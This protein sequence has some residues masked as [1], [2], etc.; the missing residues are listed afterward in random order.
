MSEDPTA[1]MMPIQATSASSQ[2][3]VGKSREEELI[4]ALKA[5]EAEKAALIARADA[6][7]AR[8]D[9]LYQ[10]LKR[11]HLTPV[12]TPSD[13]GLLRFFPPLRKQGLQ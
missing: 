5:M 7:K 13:G 4:S 10:T 12:K 1:T 2:P 8:A 3:P 6:E 11:L 9:E